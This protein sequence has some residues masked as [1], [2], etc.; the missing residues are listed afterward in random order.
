M[1]IR[2]ISRRWFWRFWLL[3]NVLLKIMKY[4]YHDYEDSYYKQDVLKSKEIAIELLEK[5]NI[6]DSIRLLKRVK[7][8][9]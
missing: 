3:R 1:S 7:K 5:L 4:C 9:E 6:K 8:I 2:S